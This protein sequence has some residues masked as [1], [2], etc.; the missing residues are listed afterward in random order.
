MSVEISSLLEAYTAGP[1]LLRE[2]VSSVDAA[3]LDKTP[4]E[5]KWSIRQVVCHIADFE[6]VYVD[7]FKRILV[8]DNP[9]LFGGEPDD[10]AGRLYYE[11]RDVA[12]E[13]DYIEMNRR[14]MVPI[15]QQCDIELFQ[16]TGV[17]SEDGPLTLETLLERI[18]GHIQHHL[19]FIEEKIA[20]LAA[21]A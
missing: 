13:L 12:L 20:A 17:H 6:P 5:G 15:L 8:E 9:T 11:K 21:G 14:H 7:R 3:D 1:V 18:S 4:I 19:P 16:R 2:A 10:F